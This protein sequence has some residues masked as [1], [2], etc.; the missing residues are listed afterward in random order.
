MS[1]P[2]DSSGYAREAVVVCRPSSSRISPPVSIWLL[3]SNA[4]TSD[5]LPTPDCPTSTLTAS[6][7]RARNSVSPVPS[8]AEQ[9][10]CA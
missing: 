3:G 8:V 7:S 1:E 10:T 9:A 4:F 2:P 5:D 6:E